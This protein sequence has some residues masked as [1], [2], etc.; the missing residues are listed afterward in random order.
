M[1]SY[2]KP[3]KKFYY[4]KEIILSLII[5]LFISSLS[6]AFTSNLSY[7]VYQKGTTLFLENDYLRMAI[8]GNGI[9]QSFVDK[10]SNKDYLYQKYPQPLFIIS[11]NK[12]EY[13]SSSITFEKGIIT[14]EFGDININ[15]RVK[16]SVNRRY[17]IMNLI[18]ISDSTID[19]FILTRLSLTITDHIGAEFN[20]CRNEEF[21]VCC[22][23]LNEETESR[24]LVSYH[25]EYSTLEE[26]KARREA[27]PAA[28][29]QVRAFPRK[30]LIGSVFAL[31]AV[32]EPLLLPT[33]EVVEVEQGLHHLTLGG[34]W[35]KL[36]PEQEKS[37]L[38][39]DVDEKNVD[40][41]IKYA[42]PGGFGY[43]MPFNGTWSASLGH[44]D[45][46]LNNFPSGYDGLKGMVKKLNAAGIKA[47]LHFL[48]GWIS[49]N[50]AYVHPIPDPRLLK[51]GERLLAADLD[52]SAGFI[53]IT[54]SPQGL[55]TERDYVGEGGTCIQIDNELIEY[56]GMSLT[57]PY[58]F[59]GCTRGAYGTTAASHSK[60]TKVFHLFE[61]WNAFIP[62]PKTNLGE[63]L[64][65]RI[66]DVINDCGFNLIYPDAYYPEFARL[67]RN[68]KTE[69][70]IDGGMPNSWNWH[71]YSRGNADDWAN[72]AIKLFMDRHKIPART[73]FYHD[74]LLQAEFGWWGYFNHS[75]THNASLPDEIE[76]GYSK[77]V[78]YDT[79]NSIETNLEELQK[80]G[81][82]MEIFTRC[83]EWEMLRLQNY[84][85][86]NVKAELR[87]VGIDHTLR[88]APNGEWQV[89]PL[90][91]G[92][93]HAVM[94][95][96]N[97]SKTWSFNNTFENQPMKVRLRAE[98]TPAEFGDPENIVLTD[99]STIANF[100]S[101]AAEGVSNSISLSNVQSKAG[102]VSAKL[103]AV[104]STGDAQAW[105]SHMLEFQ[106]PMDLSNNRGI[107]VW[108]YGDGSGATLNVQTMDRQHVMRRDHYIILNFYGW[109]YCELTHPAENEVYDYNLPYSLKW[110]T[111]DIS[112]KSIDRLYLYIFNIPAKGS[113]SCSLSR[114]EA[115]KENHTTI[116]NPSLCVAERKL[117]FP[118][119][120]KEDEYFE[121]WGTGSFKHFDPNGFVLTEAMP[122]EAVP[123]ISAGKNKISFD[124]QVSNS[125][126][127]RA[128]ITL[129]TTGKPLKNDK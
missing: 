46:N 89:I 73:L 5:L 6:F 9:V 14:A 87:K 17:V 25:Q 105:C 118:V 15:A 116:I 81:R 109:Q 103:E 94:G 36:S 49:D 101:T 125:R 50:D 96:E 2:F 51:D 85:S 33:I 121:F 16:I 24:G 27:I 84:F 29:L 91:Y 80:N 40:E 37:Y 22:L 31:V 113:V 3:S 58:G 11:K 111:R 10:K 120:L 41:I 57:P 114:I 128:K 32:P 20:V 12:K 54:E 77:G 117:V 74:N 104:N 34:V 98:Y 53:P 48:E 108:V 95:L 26:L 64:A 75:K 13:A 69:V 93:D 56:K 110:A 28:I 100:K 83:G 71:S 123:E 63:E 47:G 1:H 97:G 65:Q 126:S 70:L 72:H 8:G 67:F 122:Q 4:K 112:Y 88:R 39:V 44:N 59:T 62:D 86:E 106:K 79:P 115:L 35:G 129:I 82:T 42:V 21:G 38:F 19:E 107:G 76:Y 102:G 7:G 66:A 45:I 99:F 52:A 127:A 55:P 68:F 90:L 60:S 119:T 78:G 43:V 30:K 61:T 124:C 18:E 92:P 23:A